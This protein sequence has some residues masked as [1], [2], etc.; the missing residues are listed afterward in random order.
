MNPGL[1]HQHRSE[2]TPNGLFVLS[3]SGGGLRATLFHLGIFLYLS[4]TNRLKNVS[5]VVS[6]SGGSILAGHLVSRWLKATSNQEEFDCVAADL[7]EF[8]R[9]NLR[10]SVII[11]WLWSRLIPLNWFKQQQSLTS[12][13]KAKYDLYYGGQTLGELNRADHPFIAIVATDSVKKERIAFT[14]TRIFRFPITASSRSTGP[15]ATGV[16]LA[17]AVTASSC[18]PPVFPRMLVTNHDLGLNYEDF[19]DSF[20]LNDGGVTDNLGLAVLLEL[21]SM[22][23]K[24]GSRVLVCNAE[25]SVRDKPGN[26]PMT[27]QEAQSAALSRAALEQIKKDLGDDNVSVIQIIDRPKRPL[28]LHFLVQK[29]LAVFRTDLDAPSWEEAQA[30]LLHGFS[31]AAQAI[32]NVADDSNLAEIGRTRV[33]SILK[34][35]GC[36]K[37]LEE[38]SANVVERSHKRPVAKCL[39]NLTLVLVLS[40][41]LPI[42]VY[43]AL[44]NLSGQRAAQ[45][46]SQSSKGSSFIDV[47]TVSPV[48]RKPVWD[49]QWFDKDEVVIDAKCRGDLRTAGD[50]LVVIAFWRLAA[51]RNTNWHVARRSVGGSYLLAALSGDTTGP[52]EWEFLFGGI[53]CDKKYDGSIGLVLLAMS[54]QEVERMRSR[55]LSDENGWGFPDLPTNAVISSGTRTI[56]TKPVR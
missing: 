23:H 42:G 14:A 46:D 15:I 29:Q 28:G 32:D 20:S 4:E 37:V 35:A 5:S 24:L 18:F 17:L 19:N 52:S 47:Q 12:R 26:G 1:S 31:C 38:P 40:M 48:S 43:C 41:A 22:G 3:L 21:V 39:A 8:T 55:W 49:N 54:S 34:R 13:L 6:V 9:S 25:R 36:H 56:L 10:D 51:D 33:L 7:V 2:M 27:D 53:E 44:R 16:P 45:V 50:G 30:L 11:P